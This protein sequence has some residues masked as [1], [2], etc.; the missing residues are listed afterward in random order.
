ML[1]PSTLPIAQDVMWKHFIELGP[2][3][4]GGSGEEDM[5]SR[6]FQKLKLGLG[7]GGRFFKKYSNGELIEVTDDEAHSSKCPVHRLTI[8]IIEICISHLYDCMNP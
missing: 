7:K 1:V 2:W 6:I 5:A 8:I 3:R 4:K